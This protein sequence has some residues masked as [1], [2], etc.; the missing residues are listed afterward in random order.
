MEP[1]ERARR[2]K[3]KNL[4][5]ETNMAKNFDTMVDSIIELVGGKSN[6]SFATHC[7]TRL[8]LNLKDRAMVKVEEIKA[9]PGVLGAQWSGDQFQIIIGQS[10]GDAYDIICKKTG[11]ARQEAVN[12]NLDAPGDG[13]KQKINAALILD[14]FSGCLTP[15]IPMMIGAGMIKVLTMVLSMLN[16]VTADS[17]TYAV[18]SFVGDAAFYFFPVMIGATGAKKFGAN[19]GIGMMLGAILIH[20]S[21]VAMV[22]G[23]TA[24]NLFGLPIYA[25]SYGSTVFPMVLTMAVCGPVERFIAKHTPDAV[26]SFVEPLLTLVVMVPLMFC[27]IAPIG[28]VV[29]TGLSAAIMWLYDTIGFLGVAVVS[30][31]LPLLVMTGMHASFTPYLLTSYSTLGYEAIYIPANFMSNYSTG[32]ACAAVALKTKDANLKSTAATCAVSVFLGGVT[33]PGLFGVTI[34]LRTPLYGSMIGGFVGGA[35]AGIF[36]VAAYAFPGSGSVFGLPIFIQ[37]G[38]LNFVYAI[39]GMLVAIVVSFLATMILYKPAPAK[40]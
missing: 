30:G 19:M 9:V 12:E 17:A 2:G 14:K 27:V 16:L 36:R 24:V 38:S 4:R 26:R 8:R 6:I 18:L 1:G 28:A 11:L 34:P 40:Q 20:P 13:G 31:L 29:G 37:E 15:L 39:L 3:Y 5:G 25:G 32:A 21:F 7:V 35:V 10:V 22:T 33:E 23:G